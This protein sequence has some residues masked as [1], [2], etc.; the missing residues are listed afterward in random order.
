MRRCKEMFDGRLKAL[1]ES[2]GITAKKAAQ[3]LGLPATTYSN[4]ERD[5]RE[6]SAMVLI[7][8]AAY[9]GV[10]IDYLCGNS[11]G[12]KKDPPTVNDEREIFRELLSTLDDEDLVELK[13]FTQYLV[14]KKKQRAE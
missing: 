3:D 9:F 2:R 13:N 12:T 5:I 7:K 11:S 8:I 14:W 6:P 10:S 1:R 4:Y